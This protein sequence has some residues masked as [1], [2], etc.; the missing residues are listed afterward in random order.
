MRKPALADKDIFN[1]SEAAEFY[2]LSRRRFFRFLEQ[3][4]HP[5]VAM[6][7]RRK[8]IIRAEFEAYLKARPEEKEA[9]K[10]V[11]SSVSQEA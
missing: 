10:H 5:F 7:N 2:G 9:L 3:G 4:P 8:L 1:P 11:R 6:Y